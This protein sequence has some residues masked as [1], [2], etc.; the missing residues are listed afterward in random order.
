MKEKDHSLVSVIIPTRNR[1]Q[2]LSRALNSVLKQSYAPIEILLIDDASEDDTENELQTLRETDNR[3]YIFRNS[4]PLGGSASRNVGI[5]NA[6][7]KFIAFLDDDDEWLEGKLE[8]QVRLLE[9]DTEIGAVSCWYIKEIG[10]KTQKVKK[11]L[12][13]GFIDQLWENYLGSFSFCTVRRDVI[14]SIGLLDESLPGSQ[15]RDYWLRVTEKYRVAVIPDYLAIQHIHP[16]PRITTQSV[17]K[18]VGLERVYNKYSKY[19]SEECKN[20]IL[21]YIY[22]YRSLSAQTVNGRVVNYFK[23]VKSLSLSRRDVMRFLYTTVSL[24]IP[25]QSGNRLRSYFMKRFIKE[26]PVIEYYDVY[27]K[28][29]GA[30]MQTGVV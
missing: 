27:K 22:Y 28:L 13:I 9:D 4:R 19:M 21:K 20:H 30:N 25:A 23:M 11:P 2:L 15:D 12:D 16:L 6:K 3:L 18:V 8:R 14:E 24:C 29:H 5:K 1:S 7:G 26:K 10:G 17:G